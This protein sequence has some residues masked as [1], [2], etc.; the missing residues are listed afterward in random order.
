MSAGIPVRDALLVRN[1]RWWSFECSRP[2]CDP[3]RGTPLPGTV[4]ELEVASVAA[5]VVVAESREELESRIAPPG[6]LA[7]AAMDAAVLRT[8]AEQDVRSLAYGPA[9]LAEEGWALVRAAVTRCGAGNPAASNDDE[10]ARVLWALSDTTVRDRALMLG[11][12]EQADAAETL[13]TTC[14]S[15]APTPLDA[16]PATLLAVS[17]WLRGDGA[18]ANIALER[19]LASDPDSALAQLLSQALASCLSPKGLRQLIRAS[20]LAA[21]SRGRR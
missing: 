13:W 4:T 16:A 19:A 8:G 7:W 15:R 6:G 14:T 12:G 17:A 11:L 1:E 21:A 9:E 3:A 10:I 20:S 2:C 18:T 5:G